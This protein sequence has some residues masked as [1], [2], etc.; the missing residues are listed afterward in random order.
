MKLSIFLAIG[1]SWEDL[2]SKG[3]DELFLRNNLAAYSRKFEETNVFSYGQRGGYLLPGVTLI[4]NRHKLHRFI[5][6]L[7]LPFL[8]SD[9]IKS[10]SVIRGMQLTG[11]IP[12]LISKWFFSKKIVVN[13]GY[14]Y[15][16]AAVVE[17][18]FVR[19]KLLEFIE[20]K[21][22]SAADAIIVTTPALKN[23]LRQMNLHNLHLI[24]NGIDTDLFKPEHV[25]KDIDILFVGRLER[26]KQLML[27]LRAVSLLK[28]RN[29]NLTFVGT[30]KQRDN[31]L[32]YAR[33][34]NINLHIAGSMPHSQLPGIYNRAKVFVFPSLFEGHPKA[35]LEAMSCGLSV[36]GTNVTG[37]RE[38]IGHM[39]TGILCQAEANSL[40]S[41]LAQLLD[42][43][44][45]REKLGSKA[46]HIVV[47][48]Y[49]GKITWK[50]EISLLT[51]LGKDS[52]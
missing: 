40:A 29:I 38:V 23:K 30:G 2:S 5:Y 44:A 17:N 50:K 16:L 49:N 46:R 45:L 11:L 14:D 33:K 26:Q 48:E 47:K 35:L 3:Q 18:K 31:L 36:I 9:E 27:L 28:N 21:L 34:N 20:K 42:N 12:A 7:I 41:K 6:A 25:Q 4:P 43:K 1:E 22:L 51:M 32:S 24:P 10:S 39:V 52:Q 8:W 15:V 13:Y 19:A 37:I